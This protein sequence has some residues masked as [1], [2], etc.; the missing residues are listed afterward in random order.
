M[1]RGNR[2]CVNA[3]GE[4]YSGFFAA[5]CS[6]AGRSGLP[7]ESFGDIIAFVTD[8]RMDAHMVKIF[9]SYRRDD[10]QYVTDSIHDYLVRDFGEENVFLDVGNIPFGVDFRHY[11]AEQIAVHDVVLVII[12]PDWGRI[13]QE[14]A[15]QDNDFVRIEIESALKQDKLV[16]P[17]LVK[18]AQMPSFENLPASIADLQWRHSATIRRKPDLESDCKRLVAG[19]RQYAESV[20]FSSVKRNSGEGQPDSKQPAKPDASAEAV[21]AI[22]GD[23]FDWCEVPAGEFIY[24][25]DDKTLTLPT[26]AIARYPITYRQ[27]QTFI[28]D[29]EGFKDSRWWEGLAEDQNEQPGDQ[30]WKIDNH[31]RENVSWYDAIAFCRWLSWR[32]GRSYDLDDVA[33]WAVRLPTEY[34]WEKAARGT[35]GRIYPYGNEF[36]AGKSNTDESGF[37]QTIPVTQYPAGASPYGVIDM[38]GNVWEWCLTDRKTPQLNAGNENLRPGLWRVIRGGAWSLPYNFARTMYRYSDLPNWRLDG[39]GFRICRPGAE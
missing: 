28:D 37:G 12:G 14:R 8:S 20:G 19:I 16:I 6:A 23:P 9:I 36:D 13:M 33:N 30:K 39:Y 29:A 17:V 34:E 2:T 38:S 35:D 27:F 15:G 10:S 5:L 21:R 31:P 7:G 22:I 25:R 3:T 11:L 18:E 32:S 26:F 4:I 1:L 24:G